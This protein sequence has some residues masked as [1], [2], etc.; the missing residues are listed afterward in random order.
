MPLPRPM[1]WLLLSL[2]LTLPGC[3]Q[4]QRLAQGDPAPPFELVDLQ[5]E[6][7]AF[8]EDF[9]GTPVVLR[10]W[11]DW[12][13]FCRQEMQDVEA[14]YQGYRD[15]VAILAVNVGQDHDT[16]HDFVTAIDISYDTLLDRKSEV[17]GAYGVVGLPTTFFVDRDGRIRAK[18]LGEADRETFERMLVETL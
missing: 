2:A 15:R 9:A 16:A 14:V 12:C 17:A 8:P 10:F 3:E 13:R 18:I 5:G 6:R 7:R 1:P 11:A 4:G